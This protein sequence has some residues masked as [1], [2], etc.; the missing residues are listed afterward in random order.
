MHAEARF[1]NQRL[2]TFDQ[3][4]IANKHL[5]LMGLPIGYN[6]MLTGV[7]A[8]VNKPLPSSILFV[9]NDAGN[10]TITRLSDTQ[11]LVER[12]VPFA[13][14]FEDAF[15]DIHDNPFRVGDV[16]HHIVANIVIVS[17]DAEG[18]PTVIR[19]DFSRSLEDEGLAF[20][21]WVG[22]DIVRVFASEF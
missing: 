15:R 14:Q 6:V 16:I 19:L 12:S 11:L 3:E 18:Y 13:K 7:R 8:I 20:Y 2:R 1:I 9:G 22:G 21:R 10:M 4:S 5:V 17:V